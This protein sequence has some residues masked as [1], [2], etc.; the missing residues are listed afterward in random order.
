MMLQRIVTVAGLAALACV[1]GLVP[2]P[3]AAQTWTITSLDTSGDAGRFVDLQVD[4]AGDLHVVYLRNDN[5]TNKAIKRTA[6][7]WGAPEV[8]DASGQVNGATSIAVASG[9]TRKVAYR[10]NDT[11]AVW[12]AGPEGVRTWNLQAVVT[13][14]DVGR[15]ATLLQ[16]AS[17]DFAVAYKDQTNGALNLVR[18]EGGVWGAPVVAIAGPNRANHFDVAYRQQDGYMFADYAP[19]NGAVLFAHPSLQARSWT[20]ASAVASANDVGREVRVLQEQGGSFVATYRNQTQGALQY[21]RFA[22]GTW[23]APVTVDPGPGRGLH[24]DIALRLDGRY[25]FTQYQQADGAVLFLDPDLRARSFAISQVTT[26]EEDVGQALTLLTEPNGDFAACYRNVTSKSLQHVR[27]VAGVWG[28]PIRVDS[29][30]DRGRYGD[31]ARMPD[32][33]YCFSAYEPG[34]GSQLFLHPDLRARTY[35]IFDID[36]VK[37]DGMQASVLQ[38]DNRLECAYVSAEA[39]GRL[40]LKVADFVTQNAFVV[41]TVAD[42]VA[43][44]TNRH[45]EPDVAV[46]PANGWYV[47][48]RKDGAGDLYMASTDN[49]QLLPA[50]VP[51]AADGEGLPVGADLRSSLGGSYPNPSPG[52]FRVRFTAARAAPVELTVHDAEGRRIR[53]IELQSRA[54]ENTIPFD[55]R[56]GDGASLG[57]GVYFVRLVVGTEDL[58]TLKVVL[59]G[60]SQ[61]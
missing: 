23:Q 4:A 48:Y 25:A 3:A 43:L 17:G 49:F 21:A 1:G 27:R 37:N 14:G 61:R 28:A 12:F 35:T 13:S 30:P 55:G 58:G 52:G 42:S 40:K 18:R 59:T 39:D 33:R 8:I 57:A 9:G 47:S 11:G 2:S 22:G 53:R 51:D 50:D 5:S 44:A 24:F 38:R 26:D 45:V 20:L 34:E 60:E 6:G 54:G 56:D 15:A 41:K 46:T 16:L 10:R 36:A 32:G 29:G 19:E 31:L 7:V